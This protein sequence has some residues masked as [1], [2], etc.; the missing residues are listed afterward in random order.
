MNSGLLASCI[1]SPLPTRNDRP[2][3]SIN[4]P[5]TAGKFGQFSFITDPVHDQLQQPLAF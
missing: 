1:K 2:G 5:V 3:C 4:R